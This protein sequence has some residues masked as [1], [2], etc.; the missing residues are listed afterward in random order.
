MRRHW[1]RAGAIGNSSKAPAIALIGASRTTILFGISPVL[2]AA[3]AIALLGEPFRVSLAV[4]TVLVV[5]GGTLLAWE[6]TGKSSLS[7]DARGRDDGLP[8]FVE[9]VFGDTVEDPDAIGTP[10]DQIEA[11]HREA[12]AFRSAESSASRAHRRPDLP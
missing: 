1:R 6:R 4:G 11:A 12:H 7:G 8:A 5:C 10:M 9:P 2:S 3:G